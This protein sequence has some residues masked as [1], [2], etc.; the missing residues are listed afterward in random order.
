[1]MDF[2]C[3]S[4]VIDGK[5]RGSKASY[6]GINPATEEPLF[7]VPCATRG[8]LDHS[9]KAAQKA[10]PSWSQIPFEER[11]NL[12]KRYAEAFLAYEDD[13]TELLMKETGKPVSGVYRI[14]SLLKRES[15]Q[16]ADPPAEG[17]RK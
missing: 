4:N 15:C 1:M 13:F 9:V 8:D 17:P 7:E 11:C 10:F 5:P 2:T 14:R 16:S 3:F 12:A 6:H